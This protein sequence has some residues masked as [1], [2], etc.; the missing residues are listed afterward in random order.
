MNE[1]SLTYAECQECSLRIK[2]QA[3]I[4][5]CNNF[6]GN[7]CRSQERTRSLDLLFFHLIIVNGQMARL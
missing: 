5:G 2:S 3:N 4:S 7:F 6:S 1:G